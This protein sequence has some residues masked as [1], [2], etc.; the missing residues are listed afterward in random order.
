MIRTLWLLGGLTILA[1]IVYLSLFSVY[2]PV[3]FRFIDKVDHFIAYFIAMLWFS[4]LYRTQ[5]RVLIA[6]LL[7]GIG[8]MM[9]MIQPHFHRQFDPFDMLANTSGVLAAWLLANHGA[10]RLKRFIR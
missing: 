10:D 5:R 9:E 3:K 4:Q 6:V 8:V 7:I 1:I 2:H